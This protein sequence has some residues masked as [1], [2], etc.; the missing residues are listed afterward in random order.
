MP[1]RTGNAQAA[2]AFADHGVEVGGAGGFEFGLAA[3]FEGEAAESV[4]ND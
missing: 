2:D 1:G 3:G 4:C